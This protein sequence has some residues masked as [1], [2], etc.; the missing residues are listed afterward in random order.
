MPSLTNAALLSP[1]VPVDPRMGVNDGQCRIALPAMP[2]VGAGSSQREDSPAHL[3]PCVYHPR[4][5]AVPS[6]YHRRCILGFRLKAKS[7]HEATQVF[8]WYGVGTEMVLRISS[9]L[10]GLWICSH[11]L[12]PG[13]S[14]AVRAVCVAGLGLLQIHGASNHGALVATW[15]AAS[16]LTYPAPR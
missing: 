15:R 5:C 8:G 9:R 3:P 7:E 14:L 1:S 10:W 4:I 13:D 16:L 2:P 12:L 11:W 6:P